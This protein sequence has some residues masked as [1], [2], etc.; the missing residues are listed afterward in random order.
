MPP[1][2]LLSVLCLPACKLEQSVHPLIKG[3]KLLNY[4]Q[5]LREGLGT[6]IV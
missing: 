2:E 1:S 4:Q 6:N 3:N 5:P